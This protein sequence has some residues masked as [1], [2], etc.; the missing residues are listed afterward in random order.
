[1]PTCRICNNSNNNKIYVAREMMFGYRDEFE[2]LEC[3]RCGCVQIV[4]FPTDIAKYYPD[5]YYSFQE[6]SSPSEDRSSITI[7]A[8]KQRA[9][10]NLGYGG[11]LGEIL[12]KRRHKPSA[13]PGSA[14]SI[15]DWLREA[16]VR[17]D[18]KILDI[19][20]GSGYHLLDLHKNG[21]SNLTGADP[22]IADNIVYENG[23]KILKKEVRE[24]QEQFD[25]VMLN[26]SFEHMQNQ[27][28]VMKELYRILKPNRYALIRIPVASSL[29]WRNYQTN[30]IQLDAPRHFF[31]HTVESL[32]LLSEQAGFKLDKI[33]HDSTDFQFLGSD[34]YVRDIPL[35][36]PE[37]PYNPSEEEVSISK[38]K[39]D[40]LN[41][42]S[43]GD[44]ACFYLYKSE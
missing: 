7:F 10:H 1:M 15:F 32:R 21:F 43:D 25:F 26:H 30:W 39:A 16:K 12:S 19:G 42:N 3:D 38:K 18:Y 41:I 9:K 20:C 28:S 40:G 17:L 14:L 34:R 8:D 35:F 27:L 31:L 11:W 29:A 44:Q 23:V 36:D 2:Y 24:V 13:C 37:N 22:F 4:E 6:S 33:I 5:N